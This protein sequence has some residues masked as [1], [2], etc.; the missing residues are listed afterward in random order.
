MI[1]D[2]LRTVKV[3][4]QLEKEN[5]EIKTEFEI[6]N[7]ELRQ[8][9]DKAASYENE[10]E[11]FQRSLLEAHQKLADE[12]VKSEAKEKGSFLK[13][14]GAPILDQNMRESSFLVQKSV[15]KVSLSC[16][17]N[18]SQMHFWSG[19]ILQIGTKSSHGPV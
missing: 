19:F 18:T 13:Y 12:R 8:L 2:C 1:V 9:Q 7:M 4:K 6:K 11:R 17:R 16:V 10:N 3:R 14:I 5:R 15:S